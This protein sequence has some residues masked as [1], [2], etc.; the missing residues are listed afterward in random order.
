MTVELPLT[1]VK[2][3]TRTLR[4][5]VVLQRSPFT[6]AGQ[7]QDWGGDVWE[8][9]LEF[10][11]H[12]RAEGRAVNAFFNSLRGSATPFLFRDPSFQRVVVGTGVPVVSGAG[13][14]GRALVAGGWG[15][16]QTV[17][18]AG[19]FFTL[20]TDEAT[21]LYQVTADAVSNAAGQATLAIVPALRGAPPN[22]AALTVAAP[23][24]V[25]RL[26]S[27]VPSQISGA[28]RYQFSVTAV[29]ALT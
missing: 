22:G 21:R 5:A 17:M 10:G 9:E 8:Y 12:T 20:G 18:R 19:D 4:S 7:T 6:G 13:Q 29:E 26:T 27:P 25:L 24:V 23:A 2:A 14:T 16:S 28:E 3:I 11:I 1:L 15:A